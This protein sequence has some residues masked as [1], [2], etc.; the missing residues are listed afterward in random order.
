MKKP[1]SNRKRKKSILFNSYNFN[2][3]TNKNNI[4]N[5]INIKTNN[6]PISAS[7]SISNTINYD[8]NTKKSNSSLKKQNQ[9]TLKHTINRNKSTQKIKNSFDFSKYDIQ[10]IEYS[11][12]K[13]LSRPLNFESRT[14]LE[15]ME[16]DIK[17]RKTKDEKRKI[18]LEDLKPKTKE[19]NRIKCFNRLLSDVNKRN[20]IKENIEN[21]NVFLSTGISPKKVDKKNWDI[22][23]EK[24]F[25]KYQEKIDDNLREK[26]IEN[27]KKIIQK[28]EDIIEQINF[29][30][31]KANKNEIDK[32]TNRLYLSSKKNKINEKLDN[33]VSDKNKDKDKAKDMKKDDIKQN[34]KNNVTNTNNNDSI[35]GQKQHSTIKSTK[36]REKKNSYFGSVII[37]KTST[38]ELGKTHSLIK[39]IQNIK[40]GK[41]SDKR[42][43][44]QT[45]KEILETEN[46]NVNNSILNKSNE[47]NKS[48]IINKK[49]NRNKKKSHVNFENLES[50]SDIW[51]NDTRIKKSQ[52]LKRIL[53]NDFNDCN[54][55]FDVNSNNYK[56]KNKKIDKGNIMNLDYYNIIDEI[57]EN[58]K[59]INFNEFTINDLKHK[60]NKSNYL[61]NYKIFNST[62][63]KKKSNINNNIF[64]IDNNK[65]K[66]RRFFSDKKHKKNKKKF[67]NEL[68]AMKIVENCFINKIK[69]S[70]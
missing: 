26:I 47:K 10:K 32:I 28:E 24:R 63:N 38:F 59:D 60:I 16:M 8:E 36:I 29:K 42:L 41:K 30:T 35:R 52:S 40:S 25:Y 19:E 45:D 70:K 57:N 39:F 7:Y 58:P 33:K 17:K 31:R 4:N 68:S 65:N 54:M 67:I 50:T 34:D 46:E 37:K 51:G 12:D 43:T 22:I 66:K 62:I 2:T 9:D 27:E 15:R 69:D 21:R 55:K 61:N 3:I 1:L 23:Y 18:L 13:N 44:F 11:I 5:K 14:F 53:V 64:T 20:K 56:N 49:N 6:K 48:K